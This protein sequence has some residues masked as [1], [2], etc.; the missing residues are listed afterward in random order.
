MIDKLIDRVRQ[1]LEGIPDH[2]MPAGNMKLI[3]RTPKIQNE[4]LVTKA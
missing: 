3:F 2:R 1:R 4:E